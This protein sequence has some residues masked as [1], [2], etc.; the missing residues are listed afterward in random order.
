MASAPLVTIPAGHGK[1]ARLRAG[2]RVKLVNTHGG[3]V[4]DCWALN[5]YDLREYMSMESSRVWNKRLNPKLGDVFVTTER[6]PILT[7]VEDTS[8]GIHDTVCAAC[9]RWRYEL[10]GVKGYHRNCQD[11][12]IEGLLELGVTA[13]FRLPGSWNIFMNIPVLEDRNT[14]E[15]RPAPAR[16]GDHV[17]LRAEMDCFVV[18]STCP[19]DI[20][21]IHGEG[22]AKPKDCQFQLLD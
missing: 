12:M 19:Q 14:I 20:V 7:L 8:P 17:V 18:F 1:A 6:R 2:Q 22:G 16:A 13:P 4:V 15:F 11:N 10:L 9:D 3:Q 21:P 5:A